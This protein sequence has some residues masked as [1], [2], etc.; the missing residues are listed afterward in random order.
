VTLQTSSDSGCAQCVA[1][2]RTEQFQLRIPAMR[3][4]ELCALQQHFVNYV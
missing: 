2:H 3:Q 4:L 1:K